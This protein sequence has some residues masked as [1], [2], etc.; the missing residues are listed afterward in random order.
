MAITDL[1]VSCCPLPCTWP[2]AAQNQ[3]T[4]GCW[5]SQLRLMKSIREPLDLSSSILIVSSAIADL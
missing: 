2:P 3:P 1:T 4:L 5:G